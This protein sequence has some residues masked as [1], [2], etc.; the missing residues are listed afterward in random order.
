MAV[1][2]CHTEECSNR[3]IPIELDLVLV[4]EEGVASQVTDVICGVCGQPIN[5][6]TGE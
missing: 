6:V 4:D 3:D 2:T 1:V 5:D